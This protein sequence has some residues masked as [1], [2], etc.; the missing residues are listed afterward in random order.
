MLPVP[1]LIAARVVENP[2]IWDSL[3]YMLGF[4]VVLFTL[5]MLWVI[6]ATIG[7]VLKRPAPEPTSA[8]PQVVSP[9]ASEDAI[10]P[11]TL[12]VIAAAVEAAVGSGRRIVSVR[13]QN[14]SWQ[15]AGRNQIQ[16]SHKIR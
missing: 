14:T 16:N 6:C 11:Q 12:V 13:Q 1:N 7:K 4:F 2:T 3:T 8:K 10:S 15:A 5:T 9:P